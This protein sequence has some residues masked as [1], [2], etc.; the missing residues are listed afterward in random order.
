MFGGRPP[1]RPPKWQG[2]VND[3]WG[4]DAA[5]RMFHQVKPNHGAPPTNPYDPS[6]DPAARLQVVNAFKADIEEMATKII[7]RGEIPFLRGEARPAAI[8]AARAALGR[9]PES[10]LKRLYLAG[11][12]VTIEPAA[13]LD[14]WGAPANGIAV[15]GTARVAGDSAEVERTTLH[16]VGH[17]VDS[18]R[19]RHSVSESAEWRRLWETESAA[20]RV[21]AHDGQRTWPGEF[22]AECFAAY[23]LGHAGLSPQVRGFIEKITGRL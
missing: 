18:L 19:G 20:G 8:A 13:V 16:E 3:G 6:R 1:I 7:G 11:A 17:I 21:P 14:A 22:F 4:I 12:Q 23:W 9:L 5:G 15:D 10:L 2:F